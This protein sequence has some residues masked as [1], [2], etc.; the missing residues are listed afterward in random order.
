MLSW[1][2]EH[3]E[4]GRLKGRMEGRS[5][6]RAED[7]LRILAARDVPVSNKDRERILSCTDLATLDR[8]FDRAL[9]ATRFSDVIEDVPQ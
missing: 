2:E 3:F 9:K 7:V 1:G 6:G 5:E 8:W 4:R